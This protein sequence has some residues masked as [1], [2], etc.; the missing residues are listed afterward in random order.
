V[1]PPTTDGPSHET[2]EMDDYEKKAAESKKT[3]PVDLNE[4]VDI[5]SYRPNVKNRVWSISETDLNWITTGCYILGTGGGGSPYSLMIRIRTQLRN[6]A[7][8]RIISPD[9]LPDDAQVGCGGAVGSPTVA[10]EKLGG[11]ELLE[12]QQELYKICDRPA[13][14]IISVEIGGANG[15]GGLIL[16]CSTSM[17]IP[18]V[19][20]DWMGR[21]YPTK[22]Q[23]TPVVFKERGTIWSPI[24]ISDG[25]GNVLIMPK[26]ASD[27]H[28]ERIIRAALSEMGSQVGA[29]D[30]PVTGAETKR[31]VVEHTL[32]QSWR[33]GRAVAKARQENRVDNVAETIIEECGGPGAGKV[34]WKGKI[35]G[36]E[37]T[38]RNGH[39]YGECI[40]EG[41]DVREEGD[42]GTLGD[43][44]T[45]QFQGRIKIPFKN[46]NIAALR[47]HP[48]RKEERQED[49][50]AIVPDLV[51]VID[52]KNG[53]AIG[54]PEYRYGL[55]VIV[56]GISASD[57]WTETERG[58]K[59]GG[60]EAFGFGH[61]EY[62]PLGKYV[63]PRS[64][65]D[66]FDE[67]S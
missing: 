56:L 11:D 1:F 19:D 30:A 47:M 42:D 54:T 23:T 55:L 2:Q 13:T 15:L 39:V 3:R 25:N 60:P 6:G 27:T 32:S 63:K 50:L 66:E 31:W 40:I 67:S 38:L 5:L 17:D 65:I 35:V 21:A 46:E 10:I 57:R 28:V 52:A 12:A 36:V 58:I 62:A 22:W 14:H 43:K 20:G 33:I 49:V 48:D 37:R 44:A 7:T 26:A 45:S 16:G 59:I 41:A 4:E 9:D 8:A 61:L 24:A 29:A 34:L 51:S 53:E 18:T 64:V